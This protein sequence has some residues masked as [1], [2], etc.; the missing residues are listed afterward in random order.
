MFL[1]VFDEAIVMAKILYIV[2]RPDEGPLMLNAY[3]SLATSV[4]FSRL[5]GLYAFASLKGAKLLV[6]VLRRATPNWNNVAKRWII[7]I[8]GGITE[9]K[10]FACCYDKAESRCGC[11]M[12]KDCSPGV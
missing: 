8:D 11:P 3:R 7:S 4:P 12:A 9:P 6:D 10:S 1:T 5:T 2:Q